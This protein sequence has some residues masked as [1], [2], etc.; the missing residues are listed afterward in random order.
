MFTSKVK[1]ILAAPDKFKGSMTA[2]EFCNIVSEV[3]NENFNGIDVISSPL[4]DGGDG[5]LECFIST[6]NAK[7]VTGTYT[8]SNFEKINAKFAM[9]NNI[10]FIE[11]AE[12]SG[13]AKTIEKNPCKTTTFGFGEQILDAIKMGAKKIYLSIGGSS[14]NDAGCG[15]ANALG[16]KFYD[17]SGNNFIPVGENLNQISKIEFPDSEIFRNKEFITLCDV[18]NTLFG[19]NGAAYV[20]AKQKGANEKEIKLLDDNLKYFNTLCKSYGKDFE[21]YQGC[22]AAGGVG[23]GTIMFLNSKIENGAENFFKLTN[24]ENKIKIADLIITG[25]GKIDNQSY[26]GKIIFN[27]R[28]KAEDKLFVAFCGENKITKKSM[29]YKIDFPIIEINRQDESIEESIK[30]TKT[31]FKTQL[32]NYLDSIIK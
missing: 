22:G 17:K 13:L 27:L 14:T 7:V 19:K 9:E 31:N 3:V 12:T 16:F 23:A 20:Y 4:A 32:L 25:E 8:G 5:S 24:I 30:N 29:D 15:M 2:T 11:L 6:T 26:Y 21:F 28:K 1:T 10:A 18:K